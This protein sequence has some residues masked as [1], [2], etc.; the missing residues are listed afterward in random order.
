MS[1]PQSGWLARR[2]AI[3]AGVD[4]VRIDAAPSDMI[5]GELMARFLAH[6]RTKSDSGELSKT[7]LSPRHLL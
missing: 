1:D 3:P 5:L 2:D 4:D 7:T 6:K